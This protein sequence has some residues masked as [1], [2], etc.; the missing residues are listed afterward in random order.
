M[1]L[2]ELGPVI[3]GGTPGIVSYLQA[4]NL[5]A[6]HSNCSRC[7]V[8]MQERPRRDQWLREVC[9]TTLLQTQVVLG[10][11][12]IVVQ[13]DESLFRHKPKV[14]LNLQKINKNNNNNY[15]NKY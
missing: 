6:N 15:S 11:P 13:I 5:L 3:F 4:R 9:S 2:L 1:S 10:G 8:G 12:G 14:S 7:G